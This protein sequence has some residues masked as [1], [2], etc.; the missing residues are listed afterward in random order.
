[1]ARQ[2]FRTITK[3]VILPMGRDVYDNRDFDVAPEIDIMLDDQ[4]VVAKKF[5]VDL[6][7]PIAQTGSSS[8][9]Q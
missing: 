6:A 9:S 2:V 1:M 8:V 5:C 4:M 3:S 7:I